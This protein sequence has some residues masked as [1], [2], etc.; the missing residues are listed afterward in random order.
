MLTGVTLAALFA[1]AVRLPATPCPI[2]S[3]A[4]D[5]A[6]H[7]CCANKACCADSQ[8]NKSVPS[9]PG[10]K[11]GPNFELTAIPVLNPTT[12]SCSIQVLENSPDSTAIRIGS[13]APRLTVLCTFLI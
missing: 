1:S 11:D 2:V 12:A 3:A 9:Q 6:C 10:L 13:S 4:I 8:T 5:K 7:G